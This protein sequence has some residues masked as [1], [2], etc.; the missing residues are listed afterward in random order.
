M[1]RPRK[2]EGHTSVQIRVKEVTAKKLDGA[3]RQRVAM[4]QV[5][6]GGLKALRPVT[7]HELAEHRREWLS[8]IVEEEFGVEAKA[9]RLRVTASGNAE[10]L[11]EVRDWLTTEETRLNAEAPPAL[12]RAIEK[13][14]VILEAFRTLEAINPE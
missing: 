2:Q 4:E 11:K 14:A 5:A 8:E 1:A 10:D 13:R 7:E 9:I 12:M 6:S 3:I